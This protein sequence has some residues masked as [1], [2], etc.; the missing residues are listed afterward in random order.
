MADL[1]ATRPL[2]VLLDD[3]LSVHAITGQNLI[4]EFKHCEVGLATAW[5]RADELIKKNRTRKI[6]FLCDVRMPAIDGC[7]ACTTVQRNYPDVRI[8]LYTG[9][10]EGV[11]RKKVPSKEVA[12]VGKTSGMM[13]LI[14]A[15]RAALLR[16]SKV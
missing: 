5:T 10:D 15:I 2:I 3:D 12:F 4:D 9:E 7:A 16:R 11:V 1:D 13:S 6:V 8:I 14:F